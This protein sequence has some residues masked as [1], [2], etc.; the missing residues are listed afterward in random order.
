MTWS[1][2]IVKGDGTGRSDGI[3]G[4]VCCECKHGD[5]QNFGHPICNVQA[6]AHTLGYML[7]AIDVGSDG[8]MACGEAVLKCTGFEPKE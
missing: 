3:Y 5:S 1:A 7:T 8:H 2:K 4:N 6:I